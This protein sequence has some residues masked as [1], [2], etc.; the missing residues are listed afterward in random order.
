M[1]N[2]GNG[3]SGERASLILKAARRLFL[4]Q[5]YHGTSVR[6][7]AKE[8]NLTTGAI[9]FYFNNKDEIYGEICIEGFDILIDIL[10]KGCKGTKNPVDKLDSLGKAYHRF[11]KSSNGYYRLVI[12]QDESF[13]NLDFSPSMRS[14]LTKR[15]IK[16]LLLMKHVLDEGYRAGLLKD[17][18]RW[19]L[20]LVAL[21]NM[22][23]LFA[24]D[25]RGVL[26]QAGY[27]L[28]QIYPSL[29]D[30]YFS[31]ISKQQ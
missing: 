20:T 8:I 29:F 15:S 16:A 4:K 25:S 28:E 13:K 27:S 26:Q 30:I 7:I 14:R 17:I 1:K 31:G 19:K 5:G 18:D 21:A 12:Q 9:Y 22:E 3:S 6:Q 23:G 11:Y 2:N 24:L 10:S